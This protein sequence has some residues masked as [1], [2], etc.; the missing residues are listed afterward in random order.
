MS[1]LPMV[2]A[3]AALMV[4]FT[5]GIPAPAGADV[6]NWPDIEQSAV[7]RAE[8][9][10]GSSPETGVQG[11]VP[12]EDR[13]GGRDRQVVLP[14]VQH[15]RPGRV[16]DVG[17]VVHREQP[18][19]L[20]ARGGEH[21]QQRELLAGLEVLLPQ[22]HDV[23][24][25]GQHGVEEPGQV[26]LAPPRVRAQVE[27]RVGQPRAQLMNIAC[28]RAIQSRALPR[29][30][31]DIGW[32]HHGSPSGLDPRNVVWRRVL[33]VNDRSLRNVVI[34]LGARMDGVPR[35]SG[36]DITAARLVAVQSQSLTVLP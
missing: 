3:V 18:A 8:C 34:G 11:D 2:T 26:T 15:L 17:A 21:L 33:D 32:W 13:A 31:V 36:F 20:T 30:Y 23:D 27:S 16:G 25:G 12:A 5:V 29:H 28:H 9:G 7:P 14:Q 19:V 24:P 4:S 1:R 35:E 6:F 10:A 22:L